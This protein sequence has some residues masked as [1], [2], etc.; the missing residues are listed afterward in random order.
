MISKTLAHY[1][2]LEKLGEGGMGEVYRAEDTKLGR[3][4]AI[5]L[6]PDVFAKDK[7]RISRFQREARALAALNHHNIA[8]IYGIEDSQDTKILVLELVEGE[9][10]AE[11]LRKGPVP[12][13]EALK[14]AHQ[15]AAGLEAAHE[16]GILHRDLKPANIKI[17]PDEKI[18]VLDFGLAKA[19]EE[20]IPTAELSQSPTLTQQPSTKEGII[21][22][23]AA[24]MSPE[25]ARG[26]PV[27][28]RTDIWAFGCVLY[29][30]LTGKM[31]FEGDTVTDILANIINREPDWEALP[32]GT[33]PMI[34]FLLTRC[35]KKDPGDRIRDLGDA[36]IAIDESLSQPG[37]KIPKMKSSIPTERKSQWQRIGMGILVG[38]I[39]G[40][41]LSFFILRMLRSP[42]PEPLQRKFRV[43]LPDELPTALWWRNAAVSPDGR[44]AVFTMN[45]RLWIRDLFELEDREIPDT[46]GASN[47]FWSPEGDYIGYFDLGARKLNKLAVQDKSISNVCDLRS[48]FY[49][50]GSWGPN[51]DIVFGLS[52]GLFSVPSEGGKAEV[53]MERDEKTIPVVPLIL[54]EGPVLCSRWPLEEGGSDIVL[55]RGQEWISLLKIPEGRVFH[56]AYS[57]GF[58]LYQLEWSSRRG[59]WAVPF[60][61]G[62]A[63][64]SGDSFIVDQNGVAPSASTNGTLLY[65][66]NQEDLRQLLLVNRNGDILK[67]IGKPQMGL[68]EPAISPDGGK[69]AVSAYDEGNWD[70]WIHNVRMGTRE[71]LTTHAHWDFEPTWSPSGDAIAFAS[72]RTGESDIF[73][74]GLGGIEEPRRLKLAGDNGVPN[75]SKDG[76]Y[77]VFFVNTVRNPF[78]IG[79]TEI[80]DPKTLMFLE[81]PEYENEPVLSPDSKY[82][83]YVSDVS[84]QWEV[85]VRPFPTGKEFWTISANGGMHPRWNG[86]GDELFYK[87]GE[88]L[89]VVKV[90]RESGF[91]PYPS[92]KLFDR[93]RVGARLFESWN[94]L[95]SGYD[96]TD[97]GEKFAMIE[98]LGSSS[99]IVIENWHVGFRGRK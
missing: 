17:T 42:A 8:Q 91:S 40:T 60:D 36:A 99:L 85:Y 96:V 5:K 2:I 77:L 45:N 35:L 90:N 24:Y 94:P 48:S 50:C 73:I 63:K 92:R 30:M 44:F 81:T 41:L 97:D 78:D 13:N 27:D 65:Q 37:D 52:S 87:E 26:K 38:L 34:H 23:T 4:V 21:L 93:N 28:K 67:R 47:P 74:K 54:K 15:I 62:S 58:L 32:S 70:I 86:N 29:E 10:L 84:G 61:P 66:S 68:Q 33:P 16:K 59:I 9:T 95:N 98:S 72:G 76:R 20:K 3:Q 22:G 18:K 49:G 55:N 82:I 12:L 69:V 51:G 14:F 75:W 46:V 79:Y 39:L 64:I 83:A 89:M 6:L 7:E 31:G 56:L 71:R 1:K 25:Q 57:S 43:T 53:L 11:R 80:E 19:Q 88:T